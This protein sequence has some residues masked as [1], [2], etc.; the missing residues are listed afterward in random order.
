M[1]DNID[2]KALRAKFHAQAERGAL[3]GI[4]QPRP[5]TASHLSDASDNGIIR[6]KPSPT[7][8]RPVLPINSSTEPKKPIQS[9]HGVFPRPPPTHRVPAKEDP[10]QIT[11]DSDNVNRVKVTG[12][13]LQNK[14]LQHLSE[15]KFQ[16]THRSPLPSQRSMTDVVPLRKPLPAVGARPAK[17][18]RPPSVCLDRYRPKASAPPPPGR[19]EI[20]KQEAPARPPKTPFTPTQDFSKINIE[21]EQDTYD[22]IDLPPPPPPPPKHTS[23]ESWTSSISSQAE[24]ESDQSEIY[25]HIEDQEEIVPPV[26]FERKKP[27]DYRQQQELEK[28]EQKERLKKENEYRKRFKLTGEIG[29]IHIARVREDWQ[30]GK[31]DLRVRQGECVDIIRLK[32]NPEGKWLARNANGECG[33]ISNKCIDVDYEEFKRKITGVLHSSIS[34][35]LH[36]DD[37]DVYDD[38]GSDPLNSSL[39]LS[40]E[41]YDDVDHTIPDDF[42]LPPPEISHDPRINKKLE[43]EEKEFRKK[44][45]YDGP[46]TVLYSMMVDP[47]ANIKKGGG[48]DLSVRRGEILHVIQ[49]TNEKK[50]LCRNDQGKYGYVPTSYLLPE[51]NEIYDDID[52]IPDVYDNDRS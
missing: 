9:P 27:K 38:V 3:T 33:Y 37:D 41:V 45:K 42:P 29:V 28:R 30:G 12:E 52:N 2:V 48:K 4:V 47:N 8:L 21:P 1:G 49:Q 23:T 32:N 24:E 19:M 39:N 20:R 22:D 31:N 50:V 14:M 16:T 13:L 7:A 11:S 10:K 25:E 6:S 15:R 18:K 51:E 5:H 44:F 40:G 17:P 43:K 46:I 26:V 36:D 34:P 35:P